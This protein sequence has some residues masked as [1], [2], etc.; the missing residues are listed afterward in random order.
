M[1]KFSK[2]KKKTTFNDYKINSLIHIT[3]TKRKQGQLLTQK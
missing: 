2:K 3:I 1:K